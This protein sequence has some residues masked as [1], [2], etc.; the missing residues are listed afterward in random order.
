MLHFIA[1][2]FWKKIKALFLKQV[3]QAYLDISNLH[4][5]KDY[6]ESAET[7]V[8]RH[9]TF[10][11][12]TTFVIYI[13][14]Q[15]KYFN[16][17]IYWKTEKVTDNKYLLTYSSI[18]S[19]QMIPSILWV[20]QNQEKANHLCKFTFSRLSITITATRNKE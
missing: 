13:W 5:K 2:Q 17:L 7:I 18:F 16:T 8:E 9:K 11:I 10:I 20:F 14:K 4:F 1:L 15:L 3:F 19:A 6:Q 12:F